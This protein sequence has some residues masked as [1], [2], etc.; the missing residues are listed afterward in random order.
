[1]QN[2]TREQAKQLCNDF[3]NQKYSDEEIADILMT[4]AEKKETSE[5]ISGF[6]D[7]LL[8]NAKPFPS[9]KP[10][11][12]VCGT[13]GVAIDRF[14][15]STVVAF[16][17]AALG[18]TVA[19]HGNR[20]SRKPNGS[21]DLLERI[22]IPIDLDGEQL[23]NLLED[24]NLSFIFARRFHPAVKNVANARKMVGKRT[25]FN[26]A[27]P[28]SNPA[29]IKYQIIGTVDPL[30]INLLL[31]TARSIGREYCIA[32]SG[33]PG[34]DEMSI[35]GESQFKSTWEEIVRNTTPEALGLVRPACEQIPAGDVIEN[36][37]EFL[38]LIA[39]EGNPCL[40]DMICANAGLALMCYD[41]TLTI[42]QGMREAR[43]AIHSGIVKEKVKEYSKKAMKLSKNRSTLKDRR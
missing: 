17:L 40:E 9:T 13:G 33:H 10:A 22:G 42:E 14:N 1:M 6:V 37:K 2:L 4:L 18:L 16:I 39:G 3:V 20:G 23:S 25:I 19:K 8:E 26:L 34:I 29:N 31:S 5:E 38:M 36:T 35:T 21:F 28:L 32:V 24:T 11:M 30:S 43:K 7:C 12:D 15:V 27:G 41:T